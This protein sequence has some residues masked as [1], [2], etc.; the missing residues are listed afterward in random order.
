M[1][2]AIRHACI[3]IGA[4]GREKRRHAYESVWAKRIPTEKERIHARRV[5][6]AAAAAMR[7]VDGGWE[8]EGEKTGGRGKMKRSA[9]H[10]AGV[11]GLNCSL[12]AACLIY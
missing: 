11:A 2:K 6:A 7:I 1:G 12:N 3:C 9:M 4:R 10:R 5:R 8:E